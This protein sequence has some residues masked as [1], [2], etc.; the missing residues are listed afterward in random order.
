M[1]YFLDFRTSPVGGAVNQFP[2]FYDVDGTGQNWTL[3]PP[4]QVPGRVSGKSVLFGVH[5]FNVSQS[6]GLASLGTLGQYLNLTSAALFIGVLWPGDAVIPI[7][8]YPFEGGVAIQCGKL[9]ANFCNNSCAPALSL[10]FASHSLGARLV[11]QAVAGLTRKAQAMC[12]TAAAI[13]RDCLE[14]EYADAAQN[15]QRISLL[16]SR[17][18]YVLKVAF[19]VGDPFADILHDD[20]TPFQPALGSEG[21]P[22]PAPPQVLPPWQISD[23]GATGDYGHSD[24][25]P[26]PG[27]SKWQRVADFMKHAFLG[28]PQSWP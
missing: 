4:A 28:Q 23:K 21:P 13:N 10:S 6:H 26:S 14:T 17:E 2:Q 24:Y 5:G 7:V 20:H 15:C 3:V 25:M 9:L 16:A 8:D 12:L 22:T 27:S 1:T 19:T 11:L 18:D